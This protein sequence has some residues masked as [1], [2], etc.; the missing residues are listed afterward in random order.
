LVKGVGG[1]GAS[2][3]GRV[4]MDNIKDADGVLVMVMTDPSKLTD[5]VKAV[6]V[7]TDNGGALCHAAVVCRERGIPF[8]VGTRTATKE[9]REGQFVE[10]NPETGEVTP[11]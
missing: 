9:L 5:M 11:L 8:V 10:V 7:V 6:A 2:V 1:G 4:N 3:V